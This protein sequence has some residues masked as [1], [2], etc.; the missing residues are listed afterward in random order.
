M[1]LRFLQSSYILPD[2]ETLPFPFAQLKVVNS[3]TAWLGDGSMYRASFDE[4]ASFSLMFYNDAEYTRLGETLHL[5]GSTSYIR[6]LCQ[7]LHILLQ[8]WRLSLHLC[9]FLSSIGQKRP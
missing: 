1:L 5:M 9:A 8:R 4:I 7:V 6:A 2:A 3:S